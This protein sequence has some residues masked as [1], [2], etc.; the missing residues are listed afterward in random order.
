MVSDSV[1]V[2]IA[3]DEESGSFR[4]SLESILNQTHKAT[5]L[6]VISDQSEVQPQL[7]KQHGNVKLI[8]SRSNN[9]ASAFNSAIGF[10][11]GEYIAFIDVHDVWPAEK[12]SQQVEALRSNPEVALCYTEFENV[13]AQERS[14][15]TFE[16]KSLEDFFDIKTS[17]LENSYTSVFRSKI[18]DRDLAALVFV[19]QECIP[20]STVMISRKSLPY[21][22]LFDP[23]LEHA[24]TCDMWIKILRRFDAAKVSCSVVCSSEKASP[25]L[26]ESSFDHTE[27][28]SKYVQFGVASDNRELVAYATKL[29]GKSSSHI[30]RCHQPS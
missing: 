22:G 3:M 25:S 24:A 30:E 7:L 19:E 12:L 1:S 23:L 27:I 9:V 18:K 14:H 8:K 10:S 17:T 6:L 16:N 13:V 15:E 5:E 2:V 20:I 26:D 21:T 28:Y 11:T 29:L 4:T